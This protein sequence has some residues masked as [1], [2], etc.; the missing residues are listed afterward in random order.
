MYHGES[1]QEKIERTLKS[2]QQILWGML[3]ILISIVFLLALMILG[4]IIRNS[5]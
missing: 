2:I 3:G 1:T 5:P 4:Y